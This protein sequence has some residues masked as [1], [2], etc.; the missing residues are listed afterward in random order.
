MCKLF[1]E[2]K[3]YGCDI[4]K[5]EKKKKLWDRVKRSLRSRNEQVIENFLLQ[6]LG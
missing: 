2:M 1:L 4:W 5:V 6:Q 3:N